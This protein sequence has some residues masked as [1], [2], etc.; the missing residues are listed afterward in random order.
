MKQKIFGFVL[1]I[2]LVLCMAPVAFAAPVY[3]AAEAS[4]IQNFLD[5]VNGS[6]T[7]GLALSASYVSG[8]P[9]TYPGVTWTTVGGT[10][11]VTDI[12]WYGD[13]LLTKLTGSLNLTGFS[14]LTSVNVG[15]NNLTAVD[16]HGN[17]SLQTI[18][19]ANSSTLNSLNVTGCSAL[20]ELYCFSTGITA[21]DVTGTSSLQILE[22][23]TCPSLQTLAGLKGHASLQKLNALGSALT[24]SLDL[25]NIPTLI[26]LELTNNTAITSLDITGDNNISSIATSGCTSLQSIKSTIGGGDIQLSAVGDGY[27][28]ISFSVFGNYVA[29]E[30]VGSGAFMDWTEPDWNKQLSTTARYDM[31]PGNAYSL[32]ANFTA[33]SYTVRF[34]TNGGSA[35]ADLNVTSG[36]SASKPADPTRSG[37]AFAGWYMDSALSQAYD[38]ASLVTHNRTLYAKWAPVSPASAS[39]STVPLSVG[40]T[41]LYTGGRTTLTPSIKGGTWQYDA[42][43]VSLTQ[44]ADGSFTVKALKSGT[45]TL[46]YTVGWASTDVTLTIGA[47]S[48]PQTGQDYTAVFVL[49]A[50]AACAA[51]S[52]VVILY[53]R[54]RA[55]QK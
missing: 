44:N 41:T 26:R 34:N 43:M 52:T 47:R 35:V 38:F 4:A 16:A 42:G 49:I 39:S 55:K 5:I 9:S 3:D 37:Y 10:D 30:P 48:M 45:A 29:A 23:M 54:K 21:L 31:T 33:S 13:F 18:S 46:H 22:C 14:Y 15:A 11:Y 20:Q 53:M 36:A 24:G 6:T 25:G 50:L 27:L 32:A 40:T 12:S 17:T 8:D 19:V 28:Y 51:T 2:V 7:N 1:V